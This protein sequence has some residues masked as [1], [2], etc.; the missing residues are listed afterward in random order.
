MNNLMKEEKE[1]Q[2]LVGMHEKIG[3]S[4]GQTLY[5]VDKKVWYSTEEAAYE[6]YCRKQA[7][8]NR[9]KK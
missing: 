3:E 2:K 7:L 5:S 6:V 8:L 9:R 4:S 1:E